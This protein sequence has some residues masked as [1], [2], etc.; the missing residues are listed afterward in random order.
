MDWLQTAGSVHKAQ[1]R[2]ACRLGNLKALLDSLSL[3]L[4][5][6]AESQFLRNV[7]H[8]HC[9]WTTHFDCCTVVF[10]KDLE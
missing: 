2:R 1:A 7:F 8:S 6:A 4:F 10:T 5:S 3:F 9:T